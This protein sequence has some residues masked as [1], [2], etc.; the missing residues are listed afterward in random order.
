MNS[1]S[2][3]VGYLRI[4]RISQLF[5][6]GI[7]FFSNRILVVHCECILTAGSI[8]LLKAVSFQITARME[9]LRVH[10]V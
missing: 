8:K 6:E 10:I 4:P 3:L 2:F 5:R 7:R 1:Y 9:F